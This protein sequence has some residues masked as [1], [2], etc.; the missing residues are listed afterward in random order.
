MKKKLVLLGA[1]QMH[2]PLIRRARQRGIDIVTIDWTKDNPG[3]A[4]AFRAYFDSTT[5]AKAVER[6]VRDEKAD[7]VLT[8][9]SDPAA[10]TAAQVAERT[11]LPGSGA[12]AVE[13]MSEKDRFRKFLA[14]NG[15]NVPKFASFSS[16]EELQE[17]IGGF[18][19]PVMLKPV[20]SSGSKGVVRVD[21]PGNIEEI[22]LKAMDFSRCK[23]VIVE[24]FIEA[25]GPQLHGDGFV[26]DGELKFLCLGDHHFDSSINNLVPVS[27]TFPSTHTPEEMAEVEEE[28]R[29]FIRAVGFQQGGINVEA[30]ISKRDGRPYLIETGARNGGNFTPIIIGQS[31]GYDFIDAALDAALGLEYHEQQSHTPDPTAYLIMHSRRDG[32]LKSINVSPALENLTF[33]RYDYLKPGDEVRSFKGANVAIGVLL[34]SF[35][36]VATM[37]RMVE[38]MDNEI[39]IELK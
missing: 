28:V 30:R 29:R 7:G 31:T 11:G 32:I 25:D 16:L 1:M 38:G 14:E 34:T 22:F 4:L 19:F 35:P 20:D 9:N 23:R 21:N 6:I 15:F 39:K 33:A 3:H 2:L 36:D 27:T 10:L 8:F 12:K 37:E 17:K 26:A 5:D 18:K 24:E 13:I